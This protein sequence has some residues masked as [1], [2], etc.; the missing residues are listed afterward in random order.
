MRAYSKILNASTVDLDVRARHGRSN[1]R[2]RTRPSSCFHVIC[3]GP[4][5]EFVS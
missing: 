4:V 2:Q 3:G 5:G 1:I